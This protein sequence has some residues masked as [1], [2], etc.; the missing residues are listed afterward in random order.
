MGYLLVENFGEGLDSRRSLLTTKAGALLQ[1]KNAHIT[2][3]KEIEKR[4]K[5]AA[6]ANLPAGTFGMQ[7]ASGK[8]YVFGSSAFVNVP[9]TIT[10]Q[11]LPHQ[12]GTTAMS[13]LI[14][15]EAFNGKVYAIAKYVDGS[16]Y[17][18]FDGV[19]ITDWDTISQSIGV[20][21][22]LASEIDAESFFST[23]ST[24]NSFAIT[25]PS[26]TPFTVTLTA[27]NGGTNNDQSI[28]QAPT[29]T[30]VVGVPASG[31]I[32][33]VNLAA[34]NLATQINSDVHFS[35]TVSGSTIQITGPVNEPFSITTNTT[36]GGTQTQNI[37][38][39]TTQE[40]TGSLPQ[41]SDAELVGA[42]EPNDVYEITL[43]IPE[44]SHVQT[45][46]VTCDTPAVTALPQITTITVGGTFEEEDRF[47]VQLSI[48]SFSYSK[49][50]SISASSTGVGTTVRTFGSKMYSTTRSLLYFSEIN[51]ATRWGGSSNG[52]SFINMTTQSGGGETL[53]A[54]GVYQNKLA[55][56]SRNLTLIWEMDED[57]NNNF[58][59]QTLENIGTFAPKS[60]TGFGDLD[61]FF[62][63]DSGI[64]SLRARDASNA[65]TVSDIGTTID[66]L[67]QQYMATLSEAERN[68]AIG[69]IEPTDGRFWLSLGEKIFV[70]SYFPASKVSAWSTYEPALLCQ[71]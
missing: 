37:N 22:Y 27:I 71:K 51:N 5:F 70:F 6:F 15:S 38:T 68:A 43:N 48:P 52:A 55:V 16:I 7:A 12:D 26:A 54:L 33:S 1:C 64:R 3:G 36:Q 61:L 40:H 21:S 59:A 50:F 46:S 23:T 19:R 39:L 4:K 8:I 34:A 24:G 67:L 44:L 62:L 58:I 18:F 57:P 32:I 13:E 56:F 14:F 65:A 28:T 20:A 49:Q 69:F 31:P 10:Y 9:S 63:S 45:F 35:A 2:R 29:Q 42:F 41:I 53:T 17:H 47:T 30:A 60:V 66:T 11:S 25:G